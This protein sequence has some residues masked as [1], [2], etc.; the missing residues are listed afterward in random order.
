VYE[1]TKFIINTG[2]FFF[3]RKNRKSFFCKRNT[4]KDIMTQKGDPR[5]DGKTLFMAETI[6]A[7]FIF[8]LNPGLKS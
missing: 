4:G 8:I 1:V 6:Y 2:K 5:K 3:G 7:G